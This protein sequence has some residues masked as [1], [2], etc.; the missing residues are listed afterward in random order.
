MNLPQAFLNRMKEELGEKFPDFLLSY[1]SPPQKGIR[2]N[3]LKISREEFLSRSPFALEEVPWE[4]NGFYVTERKVGADP[5]HFA[6]LFYSQEP[7]A[8]CAAPLLGA[9]EGEFVLD[10]CAA[11]GGKTTQLAQAMGGSGVLFANEYEFSR[12]KIL[13]QNL[14]RLGVKN[15]VVTSSDSK[16]IADLLEGLCD[17]VLVDAPCSGEGM[18]KKE[19]NA[20]REWS[21]ENVFRCAARQKEILDN[22]AKC[23]KVGGKLVYSTCTFAREED[24]G[25]VESFLARHPEFRLIEMRKLYPHEKRGEGHFAALLERTDGEN[26]TRYPRLCE[27]SDGKAERAFSD[28]AKDFFVKMPTMDKVFFFGGK[29]S[30]VSSEVPMLKGA[31]VLRVGWEVGEYDGKLFKPTHALAMGVKREEVRRFVSLDREEC[32]KYLKGDVTETDLPDGWCV[33][34]VEDYPLGVGKI[35][36]GRVKNH[37]PKGLRKMS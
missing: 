9:R 13:A 11:P 19:E 16:K 27:K 4:K 7:S 3:T 37:L 36:G 15:A 33:V 24:E 25:T 12:A 30:L 14:E 2:V 17:K 23:V 20:V 32:E 8:M 10:M 31:S 18:F 28:F 34:G 35:V 6:G 1:D 5:Y 21:E 29:I 26:R 22:A